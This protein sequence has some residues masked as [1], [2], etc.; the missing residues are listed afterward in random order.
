M[1]LLVYFSF[2]KLNLAFTY[3]FCE[4][5]YVG[6]VA[7]IYARLRVY[8]CVCMCVRVCVGMGVH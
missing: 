5:V 2:K 8:V 6:D 7:C 1:L 3:L 4:Y